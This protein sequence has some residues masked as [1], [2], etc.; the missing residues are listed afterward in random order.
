MKNA[1][2]I[3]S[4]MLFAV[5]FVFVFGGCPGQQAGE[6]PVVRIGIHQPLT[7]AS[8]VSGNL[9]L[10]GMQLAHELFPY[11]YVGRVRHRVELFIA[12]NE[13]NRYVAPRVVER[14][15]DEDR[16]HLI[17]G[18]ASSPLAIPGAAVARDREIPIIAAS[19]TNP[20]VTLGNPWSFRVCFIDP[21]QGTVMAN[22][23]FHHVGARTAAIVQDS[24]SEYSLGLSRFFLDNFQRLGGRVLTMVNYN[25]GDRDFTEQ[26]TAV[27]ALNPDVIFAPGVVADSAHII[28]QARQLGI[29]APFL[30]GDTWDVGAFLSIGG[31]YVEGAAFSTMFSEEFDETPEV[32]QFLSEFRSRWPGESVAATTALGYDAYIVAL[33]AIRRAGSLDPHRIREALV[34]AN[35]PGVTGTTTFDENRDGIKPAFVKYVHDGQFRFLTLVEP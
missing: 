22:F 23:A 24:L 7:G 17:L 4:L 27:K 12:D 14:L 3:A 30:G 33:D 32:Q 21:F 1:L 8:E 11:V 13:S 31:D 2:K 35:V 9:Q 29:A 19:A 28:V 5:A 15:I 18:T 34:T 10:R 20:L 26:L 25:T 6:D 16:V